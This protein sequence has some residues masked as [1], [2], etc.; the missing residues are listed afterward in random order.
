MI[1]RFESCTDGSFAAGP[2]VK[3]HDV[4][5]VGIGMIINADDSAHA[6]VHFH[7]RVKFQVRHAFNFVFHLFSSFLLSTFHAV[8]SIVL[9][10]L[11]N[12]A[13]FSL[14]DSVQVQALEQRLRWFVKPCR[15][16]L[17][18]NGLVPQP[19]GHFIFVAQGN[20]Q[21]LSTTGQERLGGDGEEPSNSPT[22]RQG[23]QTFLRTFALFF[24]VFPGAAPWRI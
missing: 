20:P 19:V 12:E 15:G 4:Q 23:G 16:C 13:L 6:K 14:Q 7:E 17:P 22:E 11:F 18:I 8:N 3:F 21:S 9:G 1:E 10:A 2:V 5:F 24:Q